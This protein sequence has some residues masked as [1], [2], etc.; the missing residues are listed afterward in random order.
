VYEVWLHPAGIWDRTIVDNLVVISNGM[1]GLFGYETFEAAAGDPIRTAGIDG[2]SGVWIGD[3][4]N[5][6]SLFAL[7][8]IF[9]ITYPGPWKQK[10]WYIPMGLIAIHLINAIRIAA[11]AYLLKENW[12]W[13][14][15][16]HNYTFTII[17]YGMVFLLWYIWAVKYA[18]PYIKEKGD[19]VAQ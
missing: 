9:M 12:Q 13:L 7:F 2:T 15:F 17:V 6:F 3:P 18:A 10:L 11:L 8:I 19:N 14:D 16:N 4:C 1:L 5:G